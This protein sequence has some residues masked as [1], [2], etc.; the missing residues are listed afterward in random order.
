MQ[1]TLNSSNS[2]RRLIAAFKYNNSALKK[3]A[4]K[5]VTRKPASKHLKPVFESDEWREFS[6]KFKNLANDIL[7][8]IYEDD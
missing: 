3:L 4:I 2:A 5:Y 7:S 6:I 8:K 1:S